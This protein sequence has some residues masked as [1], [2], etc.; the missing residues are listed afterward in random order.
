LL[1]APAL[2]GQR[3]RIRICLRWIALR[4]DFRGFVRK[5]L[6]V[7]DEV[8]DL[9]PDRSEGCIHAVVEGESHGITKSQGLIRVELEAQVHRPCWV[10][11]DKKKAPPGER[12]G[13]EG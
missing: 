8:N 1:H 11:V 10:G 7:V 3:T 13:R 9:V 2:A 12:V 5:A 6:A 4:S